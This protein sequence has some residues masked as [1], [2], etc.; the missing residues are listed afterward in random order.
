MKFFIHIFIFISLIISTESYCQ[1]NDSTVI[2]TDTDTS[3]KAVEKSKKTKAIQV[4]DT[5]EVTDNKPD[6][7]RVLWMGAIIPGYGQ[8]LNKKYWKLPI[9]YG[10]FLG[11]AY[12]ITRNSVLYQANKNGYRDIIDTDETTNS[13][14]E[15]LPEGNTVDDYGGITKYTNVLKT[16]MEKFRYNR[17][18]SV[19][20]SIAYYGLTLVD[21]FVDAQLLDFDISDDLSMNLKPVLINSQYGYSNTP[22]LQLSLNLK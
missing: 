20:I 21:A 16:D 14:L 4:R 7:I 10:G 12:T 3:L 5:V 2:I 1:N 17:D 11:L 9:V 18:L 13:F 19:I 6:P 22:G 15:I 8:F